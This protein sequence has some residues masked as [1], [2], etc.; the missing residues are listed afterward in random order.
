VCVLTYSD[1]PRTKEIIR[2]VLCSLIT[3]KGRRNARVARSSNR[4]RRKK[5]SDDRIT[6]PLFEQKLCFFGEKVRGIQFFHFIHI[7]MRI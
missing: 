5:E 4:P 7:F 3:R 2:V 1:P 6:D